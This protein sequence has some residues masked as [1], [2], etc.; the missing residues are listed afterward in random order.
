MIRMDKIAIAMFS[1]RNNVVPVYVAL[2][3]QAEE[4]DEEGIQTKPP[5]FHLITLPFADDFRRLEIEKSE[6]VPKA[7]HIDAA[8]QVVKNLRIRFNSQNFEN[9]ALQKHYASLQAMALEREHVEPVIDYVV[10][11]EEGMQRFDP[12][13]DHCK[14]TLFSPGYIPIE[15]APAVKKRK[16]D[17][18]KPLGEADM[19]NLTMSQVFFFFFNFFFIS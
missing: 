13:L 12:I 8:K 19:A 10:P 5:G 15:K 17:D 6:N 16:N 18:M 9:P 3:P 11:D 14:E 2:L 4:L 7:E 1:P